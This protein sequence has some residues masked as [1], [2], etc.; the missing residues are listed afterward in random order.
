MDSLL[1]MLVACFLEN[2][3]PIQQASPTL[4]NLAYYPLRIVVGEWML[5][6]QVLARYLKHYECSLNGIKSGVYEDEIMDLQKWRHRAIETQFK[7]QSTRDFISHRST[8]EPTAAL[9]SSIMMDLDCLLRKIEKYGQS[10]E[11][12]IPVATSA[13]Q[14]FDGRRSMTQ[15]VNVKRLTYLTLIFVP[16]SWVAAIFSM[17][18][19]F[20]PGQPKFWVYFAVAVPFG[21]IIVAWSLAMSLLGP[22]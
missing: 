2:P 5:Y 15:S 18:G 4:L 12:M 22:Q 6:S 11:R 1:R 8:A 14:L 10:I 7:L 19:D 16:M 9:W 3:V 20:A 21:G 17:A 13:V